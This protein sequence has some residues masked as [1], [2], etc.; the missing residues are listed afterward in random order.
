M[1]GWF[2]AVMVLICFLC[3]LDVPQSSSPSVFQLGPFFSGKL[4]GMLNKNSATCG[5]HFLAVELI[6]L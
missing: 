3:L 5:P 4:T 1:V 6:E 2:M